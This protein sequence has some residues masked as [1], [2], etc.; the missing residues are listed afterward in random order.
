MDTLLPLLEQY[1]ATL[2]ADVAN[3][4]K[5]YV[6][7]KGMEVRPGKDTNNYSTKMETPQV[8]AN[9][10]ISGDIPY[11]P[12][13]RILTAVASQVLSTRLLNKIREEMGATYSIGAQGEMSRVGNTNTVF[14]IDF[15]M[16]PELK[17]EVLAE[18]NNIVNA[19]TENVTDDE[20]N[21]V[22]EFMQKSYAETKEKNTG[23]IGAMS[24]T[25]LN[26][27]DFF[28]GVEDTISAI[29]P[30]DVQNFMKQLLNQGNYRVVILDP[31]Q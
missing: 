3:A 10:V 9:V 23:W 16:K 2:P 14:Q 19:V 27:V 6:P 13:N 21:P 22:K 30:A 25:Q 17:D 4:T 15:Q 7:N 12:Q 11:T 24:A 1:I 8:F 26:G 20:V 29:T 31:E 5:S 18:V 28:N